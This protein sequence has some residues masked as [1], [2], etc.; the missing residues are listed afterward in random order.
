MA[1]RSSKLIEEQV[2]AA[3]EKISGAQ[4]R[5]IESVSE[6]LDEQSTSALQA[7]EHSMNDMAK[8]SV[9]GW[10]QRLAGSLNGLAKS[11]SEQLGLDS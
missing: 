7:F 1:A 2:A 5:T 11:L 9:E 4:S 10:R 6:S 8:A 3:S